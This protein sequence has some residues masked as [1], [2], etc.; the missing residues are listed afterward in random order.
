MGVLAIVML[1]LVGACAAAPPRFAFKHAERRGRLANGV[2]FVLMPDSTAQQIEVDVRY[3]VGAREDPAGKAGLAH[4]VEHLMFQQRPD[5]PGSPPLMQ[6][7]ND[8]STGFNAYT[9]WDT[10][11]YMT[12]ARA[13]SLDALL[14]IEAIRL[15]Y[16]CQTIT[17]D[18]FAREREVV[19][20]EIRQRAATPEDQIPNLL[21][22]AI[23]PRG[24][25]YARPVG[26]D[27]QQLAQITLDDACGFIARYYAP[28]RATLIVAGGFELDAAVAAIEKWF[29]RIAARRAAPRTP[30]EPFQVAGGRL[31]LAR[32]VERP[33]VHVI[34]P[35][36]PASTPEGE[37]VRFGLFTTLFRVADK[38]DEYEF[39]SEVTPD[40]LGGEL[41]PGF[42]ISIVLKDLG[43]LDDALA[44]VRRAARQAHR[45]FDQGSHEDIEEFKNRRKADF[46]A[47][48]ERL[49]ARTRLVGD[50]VQ[51]SSVGFD[52]SELY[53]F[54]EL[55]QIGAFDG[56]R[57]AAAI[58]QY[59]DP[60]RAKV[61]VI[62]PSRQGGK[63]DPRSSVRF[64]QRSDEQ[65]GVA[66]IDP[67]DA[68]R[69]L[70]LPAAPRGLSGAQRFALDSGLQVVLLPIHAMPLVTADLIFRRAG[71]AATPDSPALAAAAAGFLSL[72][73]GAEAFSR[74]GTRVGCRATPDATV[75]QSTGMSIYQDVVV[76]GLERLVIAGAYN[77]DAIERAQKHMRDQ[78]TPR[79]RQEAELERQQLTALYGADHPYARTGVIAPDALDRVHLDAVNQ[80]RRT[81]YTAG[82]AT[83]IVV[84]DF[85]PAAIE[86][87]IRD[88]FGGWDR[89]AVEPPVARAAA[90]ERTGAAVIGVVGSEAPVLRVAIAYP[91]PAGTD[92]QAAARAVLAEMLNLRAGELRFK[93]GSTYGVYGR[94]TAQIGPNAY[95]L[96]GEVDAE[97][98]GESIKAMRDGVA[99]LRRGDQFAQDFVRA[100][101]AVVS[102][103]L[104]EST[105]TSELAARLAT[106]AIHDLPPDGDRTLLQR[107]A[108]VSPAQVQALI[109]Q[110]LDPAR[111]VVVVLGDH[112]HLE[113]AFADAGITGARLVEPGK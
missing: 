81:H 2:R 3:D 83:L 50:L 41:A 91:S 102:R 4:L 111:E 43:K 16:G 89:G 42:A 13:D 92:D 21:L 9:N 75:C 52:S 12:G 51:W 109:R 93:L 48:L 55:D 68:E 73:Q 11:H 5:G 80:F 97:R 67:R 61:V 53:L 59:L 60:D 54:H 110:E 20:N 107:A 64:T 31:E 45:G 1:V 25:A 65:I 108:A 94:R 76:R 82:N 105:V 56:A 112:S 113:R 70:P 106:I 69:P 40:F 88:S 49:S 37:A 77:Q 72:P 87:Q 95:Q 46:I 10:T 15:F 74:T 99:R 18:E 17:P 84:G 35:L 24:H 44:F 66:E 63:G 103:L 8:L 6:S 71:A 33:S 62:R 101:R 78:F 90:A 14:K 38:A 30:V 98:A 7:I 36:P 23:Y 79:F 104:D 29:A 39:A 96:G 32:D 28:E 26:G 47:G 27:D 34:W 85:E 100:R 19:R 22:S 58:K 86:R 57:V